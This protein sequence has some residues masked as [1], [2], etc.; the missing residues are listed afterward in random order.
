MRFY[1]KNAPSLCFW[2]PSIR[3]LVLGGLAEVIGWGLW[4]IVKGLRMIISYFAVNPDSF[5]EIFFFLLL[6]MILCLGVGLMAIPGA[7]VIELL[8]TDSVRI[9]CLAKR[10]VFL[11]KYGNPLNLKENEKLPKIKCKRK[12]KGTYV[13]IISASSCTTE[14]IEKISSAI[15][16]GL[17]GYYRRYAVTQI[18]TD[19]AFNTVSFIIEDVLEDTS[20]VVEDVQELCSA[21]RTKLNI[22][23]K[24]CIDLTTS[25]SMLIAGK[26]RSGKT[27]GVISLLLQILQ[28][29][30]DAYGSKVVIIDPKRAE[31]SRIPYSTSLN[32]NGEAIDILD[33][34][35]QF[36]SMIV[37]RQRTLNDLSEK[38]GDVVH[39][40]DA[41]MHVSVL[42]IDEY[43]ACRSI[44][45]KKAAKD[46]P[47]YCLSTFDSLLKRIVTMG[48]SA[49]AY[50]IISIAE[51]SVDESGG[52]G[53]PAMLRSACSTKVLFRPTLP[54]A[55][56]MWDSE[57]LKALNATR[58]FN[59]GDA[60]F[61]STDG[62]NDDISFVHFPQM[63]FKVYAELATLIKDYYK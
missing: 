15:S 11:Y 22:D 31:L 37:E 51:A 18:N 33:V 19:L 54:E 63:H 39:W 32:N 38:T 26:T 62:V 46:N 50:A 25:G 47:D 8:T 34:L 17:R 14:E 28:D 5:N 27:T 45:P 36:E 2:L 30:K 42:F 56:L 23:Q 61:S 55:R 57:K 1:K 48:A 21:D 12:E 29:G 4:F 44:F 58:V 24:H 3:F 60:W 13:L 49:G 35:K 53:L 20:L 16:G 41:D 9:K 40:W 43:V 7:I 6:S 52:G 59:A 10:R